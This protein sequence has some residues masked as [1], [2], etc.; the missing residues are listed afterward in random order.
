MALTHR[1]KNKSAE[2]GDP[3]TEKARRDEQEKQSEWEP[4]LYCAIRV[5]VILAFETYED[6]ILMSCRVPG[7]RVRGPAPICQRPGGEAQTPRRRWRGG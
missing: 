5:V 4:R 7:R 3:A 2:D 1:K 6:W